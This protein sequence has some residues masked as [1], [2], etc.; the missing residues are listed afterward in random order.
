M[1][2][3]VVADSH[4]DQHSRFDECKR[5]HSWI[6]ED[7]KARG[8]AAWLHA[9]DVYERQSTPLERLAVADWVEQMRSLVG[10]GIIVRGNHDAPSDLSLLERLRDTP[11]TVVEDARIIE[12]GGSKTPNPVWDERPIRV[13]CMAWPR[14]ASIAALAPASKDGVE[15]T[16]Q[17]ALRNVLR[18]LGAQNSDL[19]LGH[20]MLR[21]SITSTG[22][23][24]VGH[25]LEVGL[26]DLA[27]VDARAYLIG[28]V[29]AG[30]SWNIAGAPCHYP[31]SPR[32]ANFGELEEKAY[33]IVEFDGPHLVN[34]ERVITPCAPMVHLTGWWHGGDRGLE[35]T[36]MEHCDRIDG[37][38]FRLRYQVAADERAAARAEA[39][40][41]RDRVLSLG[42]ANVQVEEVVV[43]ET[44]A[45]SPE[46]TSAPTLVEKLEVL[47]RA[48]S[49]DPGARR[50]TL[51]AQLAQVEQEQ[52][53]AA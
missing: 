53:D 5:V 20:V 36:G 50:E 22:Q 52:K 7:A 41:E 28:H 42:A 13:A 51:L 6:A 12:L 24:L 48:K 33:L 2:I 40:R 26:E 23:P 11:V 17:E 49:F 39:H 25:D 21:G 15:S 45:R 1:R 31:G 47:W 8:C 14:R 34:I 4:F 27:L 3:A 29:H 43:A 10:P 16:A 18:G 37:A 35:V 9:G 19:F 30:Q 44:R 38:E 32:R 46:I